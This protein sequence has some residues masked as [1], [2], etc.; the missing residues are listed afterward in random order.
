MIAQDDN[1]LSYSVASDSAQIAV[2]SKRDSSAMKTIALITALFLPGTFVAV[3]LF[4]L[5]L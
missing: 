1:K 5:S 2:A 4:L 3:R